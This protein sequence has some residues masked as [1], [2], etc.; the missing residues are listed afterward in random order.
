MKGVNTHCSNSIWHHRYAAILVYGKRRR[1]CGSGQSLLLTENHLALHSEDCQ[2]QWSVMQCCLSSFSRSDGDGMEL[3]TIE[4][5]LI[6]LTHHGAIFVLR[7]DMNREWIYRIA[8]VT[9]AVRIPKGMHFHVGGD[10][11]LALTQTRSINVGRCSLV[12]IDSMHF[13]PCGSAFSN[14]NLYDRILS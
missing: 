2:R 14:Q 8:S 5:I 1:A 12:E 3:A 9:P 7:M 13:A 6:L 4:P 11:P 10:D